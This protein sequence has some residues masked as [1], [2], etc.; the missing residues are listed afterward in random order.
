[1]RT[2]EWNWGTGAPVGLRDV[3]EDETTDL[4]FDI[5]RLV[6]DWNLYTKPKTK[7]SERARIEEGTTTTITD[8][9]L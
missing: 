1:M 3:L 7:S 8:R 2:I 6:A 9:P 5:A 4:P